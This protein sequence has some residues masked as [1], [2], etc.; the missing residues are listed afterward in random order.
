[1]AQKL[2][3]TI[4]GEDVLRDL[5]EHF[6]DIIET[7]DEGAAIVKLHKRGHGMAHARIEQF[8]FLSGFM[9]GRRYFEEKYG[10]MDVKRM[11]EHV[12]ISTQD[13]E[14]WLTC[15]DRALEDK[16]LSGPDID[17][18]CI[19]FRRIALM[20]VNDLGDWGLARPSSRTPK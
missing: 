7:T 1:M 20:L 14:N 17:R 2:I 3:D 18:L 12:P 16:E 6:Y 11:H 4:G 13:A 5:V 15:M 9:G 10:H 8:N 19:A